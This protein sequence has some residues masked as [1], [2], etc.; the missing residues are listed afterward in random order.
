MH[1]Q[2][3]LK[4][5]SFIAGL[6][7]STF[8]ATLPAHAFW[9]IIAWWSIR[10]IGTGIMTRAIRRTIAPG[11]G[12]FG[13]GTIAKA[14]DDYL[15]G[16]IREPLTR[17]FDNAFPKPEENR[18]IAEG[19][20]EQ[21][22]QR[23]LF[24]HANKPKLDQN[25]RTLDIALPPDAHLLTQADG[26]KAISNLSSF[27][28]DFDLI[29]PNGV[30]QPGYLDMWVEDVD[31]ME[32][33]HLAPAIIDRHAAESGSISYSLSAELA[34]GRKVLKAFSQARP[35]NSCSVR[36]DCGIF[37]SDVFFVNKV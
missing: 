22:N 32:Q 3:N 23:Q 35:G 25:G 14:A 37:A 8:F 28:G 16:V 6:S 30:L 24:E 29:L 33:T 17:G 36:F 26:P 5:R 2:S 10:R 13:S 20:I 19:L 21:R 9:N 12:V 34:P 27:A 4:R 7:A 15:N 18:Q 1:S 11:I 31:T